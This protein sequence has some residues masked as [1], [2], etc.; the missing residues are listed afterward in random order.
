MIAIKNTKIYSCGSNYAP[1]KVVIDNGLEDLWRREIPDF[2][3]L[4]Q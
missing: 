1:S 4:I 3:D 2:S